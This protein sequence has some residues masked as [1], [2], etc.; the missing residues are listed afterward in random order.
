MRRLVH[1]IE[2]HHP[3]G[4]AVTLRDTVGDF[5]L[6]HMLYHGILGSTTGE[7]IMQHANRIQHAMKSIQY[8]ILSCSFRDITLDET[9]LVNYFLTMAI[10]NISQRLSA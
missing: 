9:V 8:R 1:V 10:H 5:I 7:P 2:G 3:G 4:Y 6:N